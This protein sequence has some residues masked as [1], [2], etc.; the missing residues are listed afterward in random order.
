MR[1]PTIT[2]L[3]T[4][5]FTDWAGPSYIGVMGVRIERTEIA[6]IGVRHDVITTSGQRIGVVIYR[7]DRREIALYEPDDPDSIAQSIFLTG[8]EAETVA[9]LLGHTAVLSKLSELSG[10]VA[11]LFTEQLILPAD[12]KYLDGPLGDTKAR[13]RTGVSIIAIVRGT[14][15]IPS[16]TPEMILESDDVLVTVG[17]RKGLDDLV[18]L[19]ARTAT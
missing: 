15:V 6:G 13:T 18:K 14:E 4:R 5:N 16:P 17:T 10:G 8:A 9:D 7:D 11:G 19:L 2:A 3:T 1:L 12:S